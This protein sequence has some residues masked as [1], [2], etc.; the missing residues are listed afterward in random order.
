M[1]FVALAPDQA[2]A[3][4]LA[5]DCYRASWVGPQPFWEEKDG[6]G[7][8]GELGDHGDTPEGW[9]D[10]RMPFF[11]GCRAIQGP[12]VGLIRTPPI[13]PADL[14]ACCFCRLLA[15]GLPSRE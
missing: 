13:H 4:I 1:A 15:A 8:I 7:G 12:L 11:W 5:A 10:T 6:G 14:L 2:E 3:L 9:T